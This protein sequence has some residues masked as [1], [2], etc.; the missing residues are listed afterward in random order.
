MGLEMLDTKPAAWIW[1]LNK[2]ISSSF[3]EVKM[4]STVK[5]CI[6]LALGQ[7]LEYAHWPAQQNASRLIIVGK[8]QPSEEEQQYLAFL[9]QQYELPIYYQHYNE[10]LDT[11]S[12]EY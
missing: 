2:A 12:T 6:R 9:R 3:F 5:K 11:L 10:I 8:L 7:L 4:E 1:W